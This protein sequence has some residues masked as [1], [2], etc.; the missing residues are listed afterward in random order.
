MLWAQAGL[1]AFLFGAPPA[2][3]PSPP[4]CRDAADCNVAG[5]RALNSGQMAVAEA[6]FEAEVRFAWCAGDTAAGVLAHNN[7]AVLA[8]RRGEPLEARLWAGIALELDPTSSAAR[9]NAHVADER[10]ARLPPAQG[11]TGTYKSGRGDPL[12]NEVWV[13]QL[14][15]DT[16]RFE[17]WAT[18]AF[19]CVDMGNHLGGASGR[20]ALADHD[21][22]WQT[23]EF[24]GRCRLRFSFGPDELTVTQQGS[25]MDCGFGNRVYADGTYRR[26]SRQR[27]RF[28]AG[29]STAP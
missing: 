4:A 13:E 6:S 2:R 21:A 17:V 24:G 15:G 1:I 8:L 19:S 20:V 18:G 16:L 22:V 29:G 26:T 14:A 5:T 9:Y 27:P 11:V 28:T 12:V 3:S 23:E 10:A 25:P 7:L